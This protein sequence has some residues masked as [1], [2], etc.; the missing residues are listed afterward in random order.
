MQIKVMRRTQ[1]LGRV[2]CIVREVRYDQSKA[3]IHV[4]Q[5]AGLVAEFHENGFGVIQE[6]EIRLVWRES[7][8]KGG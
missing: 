3:V 1:Q 7:N 6:G 5:G 8:N 4:E 2:G